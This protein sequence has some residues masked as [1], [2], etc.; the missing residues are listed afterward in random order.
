MA[1]AVAVAV[2]VADRTPSQGT[3]ICPYAMS[4]CGPKKMGWGMWCGGVCV[5]GC[6]A[7]A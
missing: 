1:V 2:A 4:E 7:G 3:S 5:G 6:E